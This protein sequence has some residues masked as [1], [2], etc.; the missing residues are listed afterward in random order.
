MLMLMLERR[1]QILIDQRR[2]GRIEALARR[3][4]TS[5]SR[6]VRDAIDA[7]LIEDPEAKQEAAAAILAAEPMPVPGDPRDLKR[8]LRELRLEDA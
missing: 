5:V 8:E 4:G 7:A 6:I 1:L 3:R 2:Y